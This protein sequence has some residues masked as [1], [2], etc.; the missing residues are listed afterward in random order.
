MTNSN[1]LLEAP[2]A[3]WLVDPIIKRFSALGLFQDSPHGAPNHVLINEYKPGEGI[4][5]HED[6]GAYHPLVAT[7]SLG[8]SLVLDVYRKRSGAER[9]EPSSW[10]ILQ[11]PRSLLVTTGEAYRDT[12]HGIAEVDSDEDLR[13]DTIS[14]WSLLGRPEVF[15]GERMVREMRVS[16]TYRDVAKTSRIGSKLLGKQG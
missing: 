9:E 5:P 7:V 1:R 13:P 12:L 11:E 16:L 10:R 2:L 14:N 8:S 6:G 4:M 3:A 15:V